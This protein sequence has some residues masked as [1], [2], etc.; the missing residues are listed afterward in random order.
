MQLVTEHMKSSYET[1]VAE[2]TK[3]G[4]MYKDFFKSAF[5][6]MAVGSPKLQTVV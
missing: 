1:F 2:A 6:P 3:I 5:E 4:E